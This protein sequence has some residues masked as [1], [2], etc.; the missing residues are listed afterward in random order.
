M[1]RSA[2]IA[3]FALLA[4]LPCA[5]QTSIPDLRGTWK[6]ESESIVYGG[7]NPHHP[8]AKPKDPQ[9]RSVPFTLV[10]DKQ[11]GRRFSGTFSS[12][13][14]SETVVAVIARNGTIMMA[15]DDDQ[16]LRRLDRRG[17]RVGFLHVLVRGDC[18]DRTNAKRNEKLYRGVHARVFACEA[19]RENRDKIN[20]A[21]P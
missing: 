5:A 10:V 21:R 12:A 20:C 3:S 1:S 15:D 13:R 7:G 4:A 14:S 18:E 19:S 6:G 8:A 2:A 17:V 11:E 16:L 9:M